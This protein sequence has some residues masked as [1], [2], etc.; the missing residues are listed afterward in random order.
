MDEEGQETIVHLEPAFCPSRGLRGPLRCRARV[1]FAPVLARAGYLSV[2]IICVTATNVK[3]SPLAFNQ[4]NTVFTCV[5]S[6]SSAFLK[7]FYRSGPQARH[8]GSSESSASR[9]PNP[10][11]PWNN[12]TPAAAPKVAGARIKSKSGRQLDPYKI[13]TPGLRRLGGVS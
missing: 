11:P 1:F 6:C 12:I 8:F 2:I 9:H 13:C 7:S 4:V 3:Q 10:E 5:K